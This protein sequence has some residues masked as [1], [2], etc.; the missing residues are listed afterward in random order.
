MRVILLGSGRGGSRVSRRRGSGGPGRGVMIDTAEKPVALPARL[1]VTPRPRARAWRR[2]TAAKSAALTRSSGLDVAARRPP[3]RRCRHPSAR[4]RAVGGTHAAGGPRR[5][6][7]RL[8]RPGPAAAGADEHPG[9]ARPHR[10]GR[11]IRL[12]VRNAFNLAMWSALPGVM[13]GLVRDREVRVI[14][15]VGQAKRHSPRGPT[16]PSSARTGRTVP[17]PRPTTLA[18]PRRPTRWTP[19]PKPTVAMHGYGDR[20]G[21]RSRP[22]WPATSGSRRHRQVRQSGGS[23]RHHL[24]PP[25]RQAAGQ[26]GRPGDC[27]GHPVLRGVGRAGGPSRGIR[28]ASGAGR[29]PAGQHVRLPWPRGRQRAAHRSRRED[30]R[31]GHRGGRGHREA[32]RHRAAPAPSLSR[33]QGPA[34]YGRVPGESGGRGSSA[35]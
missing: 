8:E 16:S 12:Q 21:G 22:R 28:P 20:M 23:T 5:A 14:V 11:R 10:H 15:F 7:P 31:R 27:Q 17:R 32:G 19:C 35:G 1:C 34:R 9:R 2:G 4:F 26:P 25:R 24:R 3:F 6:Q 18:R 30:D 33:S 13:D 29:E